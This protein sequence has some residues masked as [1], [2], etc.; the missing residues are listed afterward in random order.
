[1]DEQ[2]TDPFSI[3]VS[4]DPASDP[5]GEENSTDR[6]QAPQTSRHR[7]NVNRFG[8]PDADQ[9]RR[10]AIRGAMRD[11]TAESIFEA[12]PVPL[13][14]G[15]AHRRLV[16]GGEDSAGQSPTTALLRTS[17]AKE[18]SQMSREL[19]SF[20][21]QDTDCNMDRLWHVHE[22]SEQ[23]VGRP[24]DSQH[25]LGS[26]AAG[27]TMGNRISSHIQDIHLLRP[28]HVSR[29]NDPLNFTPTRRQYN[30][31]DSSPPTITG[32]QNNWLLPHPFASYEEG[33]ESENN[34]DNLSLSTPEPCSKRGASSDASTPISLKTSDNSKMRSTFFRKGETASDSGEFRTSSPFIREMDTDPAHHSLSATSTANPAQ[35]SDPFVSS[36]SRPLPVYERAMKSQYPRYY[37][38]SASTNTGGGT[39]YAEPHHPTSQAPDSGLS[40]YDFP[41]RRL[42]RFGFSEARH[43]P[44]PNSDYIYGP[45]VV[46]GPITQTLTP[47]TSPLGM[48][49][50]NVSGRF[51]SSHTNLDSE[52]ATTKL[53][54]TVAATDFLLSSSNSDGRSANLSIPGSSSAARLFNH[55]PPEEPHRFKAPSS[56]HHLAG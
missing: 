21:G 14:R 30:P 53:V 41:T 29:A 34:F 48:A 10:R 18:S 12:P 45:S 43:S 37:E 19:S 22:S 38:P 4:G 20:G 27:T 26:F 47:S 9:L 39:G 28:A 25:R 3:S 35:P 44:T 2:D 17:M 13:H 36:A 11:T 54:R 1:M 52:F 56:S 5:Y 46:S 40:G 55:Q 7:S 42:T 23:A 32:S 24:E 16:D 33:Q 49:P 8:H 31:L 6:P 15:L 50:A 51:G